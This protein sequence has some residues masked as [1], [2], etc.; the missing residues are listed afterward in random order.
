MGI[1]DYINKLF[2]KEQKFKNYIFQ[3]GSIKGLAYIGALE[4][5]ENDGIKLKHIKRMGGTSVGAITATLL[6]IGL[7]CDLEKLNNELKELDFTKF[8]DIKDTDLR[9]FV[10]ERFL[11]KDI[12]IAIQNELDE[13]KKLLLECKEEIQYVTGEDFNRIRKRSTLSFVNPFSGGY[14]ALM[15]LFREA[16][17]AWCMLKTIVNNKGIA[18]G[19]EILD[20]IEAKIRL[21]TGIEYATF[22]ELNELHRKNSEK[23]KQLYLVG[24]NASQNKSE[25]FSHEKTP[26]LII[27]DAVR[28]SMSIPI[29]FRPHHLYEKINGTRCRINND[30]YIDGGVFDNYPIWLFDDKKYFG[31]NEKNNFN[32]ESLGFRIES[33]RRT[34]DYGMKNG[35]LGVL[36]IY[37]TR[38]HDLNE[39]QASP[40][41]LGYFY[42]ILKCFYY[43]QDSDFNLKI[44]DNTSRTIFI[45]DQN[46]STLKFNLNSD[47]KFNLTTSGQNYALR[48]LKDNNETM[49]SPIDWDYFKSAGKSAFNSVIYTIG[50]GFVLRKILE[51]LGVISSS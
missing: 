41:D 35:T 28:I 5:L 19:Q 10:F 46:I 18:E 3:G 39:T 38:K 17:A 27:S 11:K 1:S 49:V 6:S 13:K 4:Q 45:D 25:V 14:P 37:K 16:S 15:K 43:K 26:N 34:L 48:F 51:G 8:I 2:K 50:F 29:V 12:K 24:G 30:F 9:E 33:F 42:S 31:K 40:L 44:Q 36:S 47:D 21:Q 7:G 20:W 32:S 22:A 23:Y